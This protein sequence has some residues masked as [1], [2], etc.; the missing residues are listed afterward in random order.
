MSS[1]AANKIQV[2]SQDFW[3]ITPFTIA[4]PDGWTAKQTV[5][6]LVYMQADGEPT[7]NCGVQWKR[8]SPKLELRQLGGMAWQVTKRIDPDAKL[9]YS[10]F[11]RLNGFT[12][13]LRL[14]EFGKPVGD[15]RVPTGQMY[16]AVHGPFFGPDRP[17]ELFE[18]IG[19]F[20]ASNPHRAGELE[21][22][23]GSFE[24]LSVVRPETGDTSPAGDVAKEA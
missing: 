1:E 16:A 11:A 7:T 24:F 18:I 21:A 15:D 20:E 19:H 8:V 22:I 23:L 5:D 10:R 6:Q 13:Y 9:Q 14:S 12:A 17:I 2:P 4:T 3:T